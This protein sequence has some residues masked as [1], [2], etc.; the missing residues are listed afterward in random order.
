M[1]CYTI[2]TSSVEF[3]IENIE[4]LKKALEKQGLKFWVNER[5]AQVVI[6]DSTGYN[7]KAVVNMKTG[8]IIS[9]TLNEK[10]LTKYSFSLKR[11]YSEQVIDEI[12]KKNKWIKKQ[13]NDKQFQLQRF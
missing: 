7:N 13:L 5:D 2:V 10:E 6:K 8:Q 12:A 11:S 3:K 4:L 9:Q 1:P